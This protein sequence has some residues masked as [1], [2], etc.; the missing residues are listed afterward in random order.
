MKVC[1]VN[2]SGRDYGN[3]KR[4]ADFVNG[5]FGSNEVV[6]FDFSHIDITPCG[7]CKYECFKIR[8]NCPYFSDAVY[9][10]YESITNSD[11]AFFIMPNYCDYPCSNYFIL[12]ER[13][14][15]YFQGREDLLDKYLK[16]K[17]K[18]IVISNTEKSNFLKVLEY[19][20]EESKE[21][22][23]LFLSAKQYGK[24]SLN[25]DLVENREATQEIEKFINT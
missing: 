19:Q 23:V 14:Q 4:I 5:K 17:K 18:F 12:N 13:S 15:C 1:I 6:Q 21:A 10:I 16:V 20:S 25:G 9:Q 22:D 3:C 11:I 7:K 2:F 24:V 8:E